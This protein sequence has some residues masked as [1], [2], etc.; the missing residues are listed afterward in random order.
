MNRKVQG[1]PKFLKV[2][3][4]ANEKLIRNLVKKIIERVKVTAPHSPHK[5]QTS[6]RLISNLKKINKHSHKFLF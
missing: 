3:K 6:P 1:T 4:E 5:L 2:R